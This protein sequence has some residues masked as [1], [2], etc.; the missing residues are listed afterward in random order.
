[1]SSF[2]DHK[3]G[4]QLLELDLGSG[5]AF[6]M[7]WSPSGE[8][9]AFVGHDSTLHLVSDV[10]PA[11]RSQT[12][13][14]PS[15]PLKAVLFLSDD[16]VV[17]GGYEC[18]PALFTRTINGQWLVPFLLSARGHLR[19]YASWMVGWLWWGAGF[20]RRAWISQRRTS[21]TPAVLGR[22]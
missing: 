17:G 22:R 14:L 9:M 21:R 2:G 13:P 20:F 11:V 5:W 12:I 6:G 8:Q 18:H 4:E 16:F 10:G 7:Q 19:Q 3:F 1:M 15:L